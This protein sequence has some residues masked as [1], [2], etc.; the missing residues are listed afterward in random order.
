MPNGEPSFMAD[1]IGL[2]CPL[3]RTNVYELVRA[4]RT[5]P[6]SPINPAEQIAF[7]ISGV[8]TST[9]GKAQRSP[10]RLWRGLLQPVGGWAHPPGHRWL[11]GHYQR[12]GTGGTESI[13]SALVEA[14]TSH[15][16]LECAGIPTR[17]ADGK[18]LSLEP[19]SL[20]A[21]AK[22]GVRTRYSCRNRM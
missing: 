16:V 6:D 10:K 18:L 3:A 5:G 14:L 20:R 1:G 17:Q 2:L 11:C 13:C 22:E 21:L 15:D 12:M 4:T 19:G 8:G 9:P 7:Y